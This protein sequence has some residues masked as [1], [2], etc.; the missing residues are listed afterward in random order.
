MQKNSNEQHK[1]EPKFDKARKLGGIH[2]I[3]PKDK[4]IQ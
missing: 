2:Y 1:E 3:D 4:E